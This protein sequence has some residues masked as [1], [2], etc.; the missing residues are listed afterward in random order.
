MRRNSTLAKA[1]A[2]MDLSWS[3]PPC[4]QITSA[5]PLPPYGEITYCYALPHSSAQY[6]RS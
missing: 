3:P 2:L 6:Y 5:E 4:C 1:I